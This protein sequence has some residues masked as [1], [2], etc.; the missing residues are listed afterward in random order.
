MTTEGGDAATTLSQCSVADIPSSYM[1]CDSLHGQCRSHRRFAIMKCHPH[2]LLRSINVIAI[3][4]LALAACSSPGEV[5]VQPTT[6]LTISPTNTLLPPSATPAPT[7]G[8][9]NGADFPTNVKSGP[10][11]DFQW[12]PLTYSQFVGRAAGNRYYVVCSSGTSSTILSFLSGSI[13]KGGW[14]ISS[15]TPTTLTAQKPTNPPSG[16]CFSFLITVGSHPSNPGEY[17]YN[18]HSPTLSC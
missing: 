6:T 17:D 3:T 8:V 1:R 4:F 11:G 14:T 5:S 2:H 15:I 12:P 18:F 9:C 13:P 16:F 7:P 10:N